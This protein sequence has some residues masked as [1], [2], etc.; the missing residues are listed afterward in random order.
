MLACSE[1][2]SSWMRLYQMCSN[3]THAKAL[4][5]ALDEMKT[6][7]PKVVEMWSS[8]LKEIHPS[9]RKD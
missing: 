5:A 2:D 4:L 3:I 6:T 9:L 7:N 1:D 8:A